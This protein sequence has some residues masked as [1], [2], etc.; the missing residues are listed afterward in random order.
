[1]KTKKMSDII[2]PILRLLLVV[3]TITIP[4]SQIG[5]EEADSEKID[6]VD[7]TGLETIKEIKKILA[8]LDQFYLDQHKAGIQNADLSYANRKAL[9]LADMLIN[10]SGELKTDLISDVSRY[11]FASDLQ[12][13]ERRMKKILKKL[14]ELWQFYFK[15]VDK[16]D[17]TIDNS[18]LALKALFSLSPED[19]L[20]NRHAK[21]ATLA[22]LLAPT[23]QD[24]VW[25]CFDLNRNQIT[26]YVN[27]MKNYDEIIEKGYLT[28]KK[29]GQHDQ[30]PFVNS[31]PDEDLENIFKV[32][33]LGNIEGTDLKLIQ[34]PGFA[35]ALTVMGGSRIKHF[36]EKLIFVL[37]IQN[38]P[39]VCIET[40]PAQVISAMAKV[41]AH[42]Q[43]QAD[44]NDLIYAGKYA[45]SSLTHN[46]IL[47]ATESALAAMAEDAF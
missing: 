36:L 40:T 22:A 3:Y 17:H 20:N 35:A 25:D 14:N 29:N 9:L 1:M 24:P 8:Q 39:G 41:I 43:P 33:I 7:E 4:V 27:C 12:E 42:H 28:Q 5:A 23:D 46:P 32:G 10:S 13:P 26:Y 21:V 45:F 11:F 38:F 31:I 6:C 19:P 34:A 15:I 16:P 30:F 44:V 47:F 37:F 18:N 2:L